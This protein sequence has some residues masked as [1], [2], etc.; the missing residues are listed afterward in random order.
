MTAKYN[1]R[2][3]IFQL[4]GNLEMEKGEAPLKLGGVIA[5]KHMQLK[6]FLF[7]GRKQITQSAQ[8]RRYEA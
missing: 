2:T 6:S 8:S 4:Y 3:F 1:P 5:I 7:Q